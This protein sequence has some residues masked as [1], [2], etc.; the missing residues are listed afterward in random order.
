[1]EIN[2]RT[3]QLLKERAR[4]LAEE[5]IDKDEKLEYIEVVEFVL[6]WEHY[7]MDSSF[8]REVHPLKEFT[9]VPC[10]PDF[11]VGISNIRG[12][13][14]S[15][16]DIKK[17]FGLPE[18]GLTDLNRVII[19]ETPRMELGIL[20]DRINGIR[21]IRIQDLQSQL[22]TLTGIRAD[23]LRGVTGDRMVVLDVEKI[24]NDSKII[25]H[26]EVDV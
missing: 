22:P 12:Q 16:I 9:P 26:E 2:P 7:G 24:L 14:L 4:A 23:Y 13:I 21:R 1:M 17:F 5:Q 10:T 19:V 15:I 18:K 25:I 11:V 6:S 8:I 3:K 20:A